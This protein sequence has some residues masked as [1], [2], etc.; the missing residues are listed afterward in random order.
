MQVGWKKITAMDRLIN[1]FKKRERGSQRMHDLDKAIVRSNVFAENA[2]DLFTE[3]RR[4]L[5]RLADIQ[6]ER[7]WVHDHLV[8]ELDHVVKMADASG[9]A[10]EDRDPEEW[11]P[12]DV[13]VLTGTYYRGHGKGNGKCKGS[14]RPRLDGTGKQSEQA[15]A[16][17][18]ACKHKVREEWTADDVPVLTGTSSRARGK[19]RGKGSKRKKDATT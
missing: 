8:R 3:E 15:D 4:I 2:T 19:G 13:P 11:T 16:S 6:S 5:R 12:D 1:T 7:E 9:Q 17:G 14:K 10:C 18:Q